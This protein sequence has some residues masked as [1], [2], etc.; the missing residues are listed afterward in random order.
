M[1]GKLQRQ[2]GRRLRAIRLQRDFS[3]EKFADHL[4]YHRTYIGGIERGERNLSLQS[5]E[6]LAERLG[7][8]PLDLLAD[9]DQASH[10]GS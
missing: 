8:E 3:Q 6:E 5:V 1:T 7:V 9:P 10:R 2:L 4:G